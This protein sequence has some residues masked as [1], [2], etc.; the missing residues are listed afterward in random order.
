MV[1]WE[2]IGDMGQGR[3][4]REAQGSG[5]EGGGVVGGRVGG[6]GKDPVREAREWAAARRGTEV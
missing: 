1:F 5:Q 6:R 2:E 4:K 3:N